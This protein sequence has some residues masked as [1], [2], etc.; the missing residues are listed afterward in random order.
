ME[1]F[2]N[3]TSKMETETIS[4]NGASLKSQTS[5]RNFLRYI[6]ALLTVSILFVGCKKDDA[7]SE[8]NDGNASKII[9]TNV[10][11]G[12]TKIITVK[13]LQYL[14][15]DIYTGYKYNVIAE[16]EYKNNGFTLELPATVSTKYLTS[17]LE[18]GI[19]QGVTVSDANALGL[20]VNDFICYDV[21]GK[22]IGLCSFQNS[23]S[24][25]KIDYY[26]FWIYVDR[27]VT[28]KGADKYMDTWD[29]NLKKGWNIVYD[30][31][32]YSSGES[33]A[34]TTQKPSGVNYSWIF[35]PNTN[36]N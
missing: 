23:S 27:D 35:E 5:R 1:Q 11:N 15:Y 33:D 34:Y 29:L 24:S 31:Y 20:K 7:G 17:L 13:A 10:T 2:S 6:F 19:P 12:S 36:P 14:G 32:S 30:T 4:K 28:F 16:A 3:L 18:E 21:N 25:N 9:A 8:G 26:T 22:E